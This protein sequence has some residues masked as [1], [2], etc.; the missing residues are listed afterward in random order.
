[1]SNFLIFG[2][3]QMIFTQKVLNVIKAGFKRSQLIYFADL[4]YSLACNLKRYRLHEN[5]LQTETFMCQKKPL[6]F[7]KLLYIY[8]NMCGSKGGGGGWK[9]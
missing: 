4:I 3:F 1:M 5:W 7:S 8:D 2:V 6:Y 9:I